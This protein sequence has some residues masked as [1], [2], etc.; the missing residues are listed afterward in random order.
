MALVLDEGQVQRLIEGDRKAAAK[1]E[2]SIEKLHELVEVER[3]AADLMIVI[4][5]VAWVRGYLEGG[6]DMLERLSKV[7][8]EAT[9]SI[10]T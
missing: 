10:R 7:G 8:E 6:G 1:L 2:D 3:E 4:E 5:N 9:T